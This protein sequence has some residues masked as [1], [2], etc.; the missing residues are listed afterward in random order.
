MN[1][2][3]LEYVLAVYQH[4]SFVKAAASCFVTQPTLSA[5]IQKLEE[6]LGV[7]IFDRSVSPVAVTEAGSLV[8]SK[9]KQVLTAVEDLKN[10]ASNMG[11]KVSGEYSIGI[12]PTIAPSLLSC[13][14]ELS[15]TYNEL[16]LSVVEAQTP[17]IIE[18]LLMGELHAAIAATP[19][20]ERDLVEQPLYLEPLNVFVSSN[21]KKFKK[22]ILPK[23]I[24]PEHVW[25]LEEGNCLSKQFEHLCSL[26]NLV[27]KQHNLQVKTGSV[28]TLLKLVEENNGVTILPE[29]FCRDLDDEKKSQIRKFKSPQPFRQ[30]SLVFKKGFAKEII[31]NT[32]SNHIKHY[33][34]RVLPQNFKKDNIQIVPAV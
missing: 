20:F 10:V 4:K 12:I 9:M 17:T 23:D 3:Q 22:Y 29:L 30:V 2:Q 31:N 32:V 8:I 5:M 18:K 13:F 16:N 25:M 33:I 15:K 11:R 1:F 34:K 7:K 14:V 19:L 24:K 28:E 27:N 6:E 21:E 26:K